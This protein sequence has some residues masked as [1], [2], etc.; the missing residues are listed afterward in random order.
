MSDWISI[1]RWSECARMERPGI[2]FEIRNS[3]GQSLLT[4]C[5]VPLPETPFDWKSPPVQ[6][7][8]VPAPRPR[9]STPIPRPSREGR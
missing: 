3:E 6:F 1:E 4:R 9:H 5:V 8:A 2:I 7:R